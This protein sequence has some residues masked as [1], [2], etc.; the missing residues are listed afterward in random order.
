MKAPFVALMLVVLLVILAVVSGENVAESDD[1]W[2]GSDDVTATDG[3]SPGEAVITWNQAEQASSHRI[4]WIAATDRKAGTGGDA[5]WLGDFILSDLDNHGQASRLMTGLRPG[6][7]D[8]FDVPKS[9]SRG[10]RPLITTAAV[11]DGESVA[12][13][14]EADVSDLNLELARK[15]AP[16]LRMHPEER[17]LPQGVEALIDN[18]ILTYADEDLPGVATLVGTVTPDMLA[19][20]IL[21]GYKDELAPEL[22]NQYDGANWYLDVPNDIREEPQTEYPP[23]IYAAVRMQS[24]RLYLQY[25]MFYYYDHLNTGLL[26]DKCVELVKGIDAVVATLAAEFGYSSGVDGIPCEPHEADWEFLQLEFEN[27][28]V[29]DILDQDDLPKRLAYSQHHWNE[30]SDFEDIPTVRRHPIVYVAHGKHASFFGP[31]PY[32]LTDNLAGDDPWSVAA[33]QDRIS[34]RGA[35]LLPPALSDYANPCPD[36]ILGSGAVCTH[37]YEL[38][39]ID[40]QVPWVAFEGGWGES[41]YTG[42]DQP[43]KWDSPRDWMNFLP[44]DF[45]DQDG[46]DRDRAILNATYYHWRWNWPNW[47]LFSVDAIVESV[48]EVIRQTFDQRITELVFFDK[49]EE[50]DSFSPKTI[51]PSLGDLSHLKKLDIS[52]NGLIGVI[53]RQLGYLAQLETLDLS[54]NRLS[55]EIPPE[56]ALLPS[57]ESLHL[58]G[59]DLEGCIP[60]G[61]LRVPDNDLG[62]LGL[63]PC[64]FGDPTELSAAPG[65]QTGEVA[66]SWLPAANATVQWVYLVKPDGTDGRYWPDAQAGDAATLTVTGLEPGQTY[67]FLV[68]AGREDGQGNVQ[69]S[70]WSNWGQAMPAGAVAPA[71]EGDRIVLHG[72]TLNG[73]H[74]DSTNPSL[75]VPPGQ[76]ISG[77]V[78]LSVTNHHGGHAIFPVGATTTW[79]PHQTSYWRLPIRP[80][81]FGTSRQEVSINLTAPEQPGNYAIIFAAQ[82]ETSLGHVMSGTHWP[83]GGPRWDNGDDVAGWNTSQIDFAIAHG[84]VLAPQH[85]WGQPT[86]RFG[87]AAVKI[88][89]SGDA[90]PSGTLDNPTGLTATP[91]SH[92]GE[93]VLRWTP[94]ANAEFYEVY[95]WKEGDTEGYYWQGSLGGDADGLTITNLEVGQTYRFWVRAGQ[96]QST[97]NPVLSEWSNVGEAIPAGTV[98]MPTGEAFARNAAQ[99]FDGLID[100]PWGIWSDGSTMWVSQ[101]TGKV[102]AYDR[103]TKSRVPSKEFDIPGNGTPVGLW[104][105]GSTIWVADW[106]ADKIFAFDLHTH[107][108]IPSQDF[109]NLSGEGSAFLLGIWS[110]GT[111]MWV[112]NYS[113]GKIYAY[114]MTTKQRVPDEDFDTLKAAGNYQPEGIWSDGVTMWVSNSHTGGRKIYG[115]D[116]TTKARVPAREFDTL[117]GAGQS[118]PKGLWSDGATM[119]VADKGQ[120]KLYAYHMPGPAATA[121]LGTP[122]GLTATTGSQSGEVALRWSPA[123][124][125]TVHWVYLVKPDGTDGRYWPHALAGDADGVTITGLDAGEIYWFLVIAGQEQ[126]DGTPLWSQWSNWARGTPTSGTALTEAQMSF[127]S[128]SYH[129]CGL[130]SDGTSVCWGDNSHDQA[131]PPAGE[132]FTAISSGYRH[133]CGLRS[134]GTAICWGDDSHGQASPPAGETFAA[135]SSGTW[136]TCGLRTDG[137]AICWGSSRSPAETFAT[138]SSGAYHTCGLRM[139]DSV[140]C[141]GDNSHGQASPPAGETFAAISSGTFHT[142]GL[143]SDGSVACW[144]SNRHGQAMPSTGETFAAISSG[145]EYTC[146]LRTDGLVACWGRNDDGPGQAT[147]PSGETFAAISSGGLHA[148]GLRASGSVACWG[149]NARGQATA[150]AGVNFG[151]NQFNTLVGSMLVDETEIAISSDGSHTCGL[152]VDGSAVCWGRNSHGQATPPVGETFATISSGGWHTCGLRADGSGVVICWGGRNEDRP[153]MPPAGETFATVSSGSHHT[154]GLRVDGSA[155]CWGWNRGGQASPPN[156]EVFTAISSGGFHTCGLRADGSPVCWGHF[157]GGETMPPMGETFVTISSG[158]HHVCGLRVD[159]SAVCWGRNVNGETTLPTGNTF[160]A[161]SGGAYHTC[162]LRANG[163]AVCWGYNEY[164]QATPPVGETFAAISSGYFHTCGLRANGSVVC[165]GH[166]DYGQ[167]TPTA[168]VTFAVNQ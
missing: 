111:T 50:L 47:E 90:S 17:F 28:D 109:N 106:T 31:D 40:E 150:P 132:T 73:N 136:H 89:V 30:D 9:P 155:V 103:V 8:L 129:T 114:D 13:S 142:C 75:R 12:A 45:N 33:I 77:T 158:S 143:G 84:Y 61:L 104:S 131:S 49:E 26:Q 35:E 134:D 115:Y 162:G 148:C 11:G 59:N 166:N 72:G 152:K 48:T 53:P 113:A 60:Y 63:R 120:D 14:S 119:W 15:F 164:G 105:D 97:G 102:F 137:R 2:L 3:T 56:L 123:D 36:G 79:G 151:V 78:D 69:W 91:G 124:N 57:L 141:W 144:G 121:P 37:T 54:N 76:S 101:E 29:A 140:V 160:A 81:A 153:V 21:D 42:P 22:A 71:P 138:I 10:Y 7:E 112:S 62:D 93:V 44:L 65:S 23:K 130:R 94:A 67:Y 70:Q 39:L 116:L 145:S 156:G 139:D 161:I 16:V 118:D 146:A 43:G 133:T 98:A 95:I 34:D 46:R 51:P 19:P 38:E 107:A 92:A 4:G 128:G 80:P 85:G 125:A 55:G 88:V 82:A 154:C 117:S 163:S 168:G 167:A 1:V 122:S 149:Q 66:L 27:D 86:A 83:S 24:G 5:G 96:G 20:D 110:D 126:S 99:D 52:G 32:L 25:H 64:S 157:S 147:P 108:R 165:W 135:I 68:I 6:M 41:K 159:G 87:A 74:I 18:A 58:G 127:S 100:G